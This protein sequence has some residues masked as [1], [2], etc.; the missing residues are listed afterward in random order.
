MWKK[1]FCEPADRSS[2]V[3]EH[4]SKNLTLPPPQLFLVEGNKKYRDYFKCFVI[5]TPYFFK[6]YLLGGYVL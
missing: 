3:V 1:M 4:I 5:I 2:F 6:P